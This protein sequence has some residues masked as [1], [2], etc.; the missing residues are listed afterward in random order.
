[1]FP[2]LDVYFFLAFLL[3]LFFVAHFFGVVYFT[4]ASCNKTINEIIVS[5]F[6]FYCSC[7]ISFSFHHRTKTTKKEYREVKVKIKSSDQHSW[8]ILCDVCTGQQTNIMILF[9]CFLF[10][11]W[12]VKKSIYTILWFNRNYLEFMMLLLYIMVAHFR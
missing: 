6:L 10:S 5:T 8:E 12:L 3:L 9:I 7:K 4:L 2:Y 11:Y 1:M